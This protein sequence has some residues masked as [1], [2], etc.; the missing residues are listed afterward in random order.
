MPGRAWVASWGLLD[1]TSSLLPHC[2]LRSDAEIRHILA[3]S[4][5]ASSSNT[6]QENVSLRVKFLCWRNFLY[7]KLSP[8]GKCCLLSDI[9][10]L[11]R[12][13]F[14]SKN[15][16]LGIILFFWEIIFFI[17]PPPTYTH[18]ERE[19]ERERERERE[20]KRKKREICLLVTFW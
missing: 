18:N 12:L 13:T 10:F 7:C 9:N 19:S 5:L 20:K 1:P 17:P 11:L 3:T 2:V 16:H 15:F 4:F 14:L 6:S 8:P